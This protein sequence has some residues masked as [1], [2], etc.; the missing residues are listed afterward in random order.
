MRSTTQSL[1]ASVPHKWPWAKI[2]TDRKDLIFCFSKSLRRKPSISRV[3]PANILPCRPSSA[4]RPSSGS[5][6]T[7]DWMMTVGGPADA[8]HRL[9]DPIGGDRLGEALSPGS[10][11][12]RNR[13]ALWPPSDRPEIS[14]TSSMTGCQ[15]AASRSAARCA[16]RRPMQPGLGDGRVGAWRQGF[17]HAAVSSRAAGDGRV[18]GLSSGSEKI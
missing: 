7:I 11:R 2:V 4:S 14:S 15:S 17:D 18:S 6:W 13:M 3:R 1:M 5:E 8:D 12:R 9:V 16:P 10:S